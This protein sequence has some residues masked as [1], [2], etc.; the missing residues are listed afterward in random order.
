MLVHVVIIENNIV[1]A[2]GVSGG[3]GGFE[4]DAAAAAAPRAILPLRSCPPVTRQREAGSIDVAETWS[5]DR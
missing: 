3:G 4:D 2:I 5:A 1:G